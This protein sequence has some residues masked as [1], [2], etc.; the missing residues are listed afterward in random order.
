MDLLR[1]GGH[2][3]AP[4]GQ[5]KQFSKPLF[6]WDTD[7]GCGAALHASRCAAERKTSRTAWS[8]HDS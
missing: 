7:T 8:R 5:A 1:S 6:L 4:P 2:G 3:Q